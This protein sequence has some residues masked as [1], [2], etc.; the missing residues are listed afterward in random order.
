MGV[1]VHLAPSSAHVAFTG[2]VAIAGTMVSSLN[3]T[4]TLVRILH[5]ATPL[6][7]R[8]SRRPRHAP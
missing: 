5:A 6:R 2:L 1:F 7:R 8:L 4:V 3:A